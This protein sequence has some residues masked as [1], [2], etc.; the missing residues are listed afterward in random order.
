M[1]RQDDILETEGAS[2]LALSAVEV[3]VLMINK[4]LF[5]KNYM[6]TC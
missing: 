1:R 3:V 5:L 4:K 6:I 2:I